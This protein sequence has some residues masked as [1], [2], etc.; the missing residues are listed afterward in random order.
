MQGWQKRLVF[1]LVILVAL[2][3]MGCVH[4]VSPGI[5]EQASPP[6]SFT[7]LRADTE[8]YKDRVV[9]L[10]GEIVQTHNMP[11]GSLIEVVQ[12]PLDAAEQPVYTDATGGRFQA[13]C[14]QYLDPAVYAQGRN[15]TVAGQVLGTRSGQVGEIDYTYPLISCLELHLWPEAVPVRRYY[16]YYGDFWYGD[17]WFWRP[18]YWGFYVYKRPHYHYRR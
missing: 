7:Q 13:L 5:R 2:A 3:G 6:I 1:S 12:K 11:E 8:S 9:I 14:E 18:W 10:G 17:P 16:S 4:T 15:I